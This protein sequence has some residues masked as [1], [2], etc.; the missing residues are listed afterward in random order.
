M[1][2]EVIDGWVCWKAINT[3]INII[4]LKIDINIQMGNVLEEGK[5]DKDEKSMFSFGK[6][7]TLCGDLSY[8]TRIIGWLAC[9]IT[10]M[11]LSFIVSLV[12]VF[13]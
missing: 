7:K 4:S 6:E 12:F 3:F 13:S 10:G 9:S 11:L 8:K 5:G 2:R 1:K